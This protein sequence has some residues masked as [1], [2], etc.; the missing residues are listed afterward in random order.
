MDFPDV[1]IVNPYLPGTA[2]VSFIRAVSQ[3][4]GAGKRTVEEFT[5]ALVNIVQTCDRCS[6]RCPRAM[7]LNQIVHPAWADADPGLLPR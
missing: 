5:H 3:M 2:I 4:M 1:G 7:D 6:S